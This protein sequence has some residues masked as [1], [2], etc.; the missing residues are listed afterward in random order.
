MLERE[1]ERGGGVG[2]EGRKG[3]AQLTPSGVHP[4]GLWTAA[5]RAEAEREGRRLVG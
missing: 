2:E 5:V 3:E 4:R 1:R